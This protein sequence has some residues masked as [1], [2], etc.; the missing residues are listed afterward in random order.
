MNIP[1]TDIKGNIC[2]GCC[3]TDKVHVLGVVKGLVPTWSDQGGE[4]EI[5]CLDL[6][7]EGRRQP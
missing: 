6:K 4:M 1:R 7:G 3:I 2:P 5:L